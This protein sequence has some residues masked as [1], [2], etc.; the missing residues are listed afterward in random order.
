[1]EFTVEFSKKHEFDFGTKFNTKVSHKTEDEVTG[2]ENKATY[3]F[4]GNKELKG[5]I[6]LDID[7]YVIVVEEVEID[8]KQMKLK[9]IVGKK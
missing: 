9:K 3:Y 2:I 4:W 1:M 6:D 7:S 5:T 8:G